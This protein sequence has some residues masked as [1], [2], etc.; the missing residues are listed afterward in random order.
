MG[1][2]RLSASRFKVKSPPCGA[3]SVVPGARP[4]EEKL[5]G[6]QDPY[7]K[8]GPSKPC[9]CTQGIAG[10]HPVPCPTKGKCRSGGF[11]SSSSA[12][13]I[14][15]GGSSSFPRWA[16]ELERIISMSHME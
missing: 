12:A 8:P 9:L 10:S 16:Q 3:R 14:L 11:W 2:S 5:L 6:V 7:V 15:H 4:G 1:R 13:P